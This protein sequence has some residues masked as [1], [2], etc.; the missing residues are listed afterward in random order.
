MIFTE[1]YDK[2][3]KKNKKRYEISERKIWNCA[4][5][6]GIRSDVLG[7][8]SGTAEDDEEPVQDADDL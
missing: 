6:S 5:G 3:G 7:S 2:N 4:D 8:Y 1:S